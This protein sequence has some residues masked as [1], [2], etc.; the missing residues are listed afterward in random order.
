YTRH[1]WLPR[2]GAD[3]R[4]ISLV[5]ADCPC[6][7][8]PRQ[9]FAQPLIPLPASLLPRRSLAGGRPADR[10][11][12]RRVVQTTRRVAQRRTNHERATRVAGNLRAVCSSMR[13]RTRATNSRTY[14]AVP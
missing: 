5:G 9:P 11:G 3:G 4:P 2:A 1:C 6:L 8:S 13:A 7:A 10:L 14:A 12:L